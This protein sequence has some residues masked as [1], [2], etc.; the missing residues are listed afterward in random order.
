MKWSIHPK[1]K[2]PDLWNTHEVARFLGVQERTVLKWVEN[3]REGFP[4]C[5]KAYGKSYFWEKSKIEAFAKTHNMRS[6]KE[7]EKTYY[8]DARKY[9]RFQPWIM[10]GNRA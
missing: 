6:R 10:E 2:N 8:C 3:K 7:S 4:I 9:E 1:N 5:A